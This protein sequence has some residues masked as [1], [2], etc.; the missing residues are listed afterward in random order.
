MVRR[1]AKK[2]SPPGCL[3]RLARVPP[4]RDVRPVRAR[5]PARTAAGGALPAHGEL[6][7]VEAG[8][9]EGADEGIREGAAF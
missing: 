1:P 2:R 3:P 4:R 5:G 8:R 9:D 6:G 7:E